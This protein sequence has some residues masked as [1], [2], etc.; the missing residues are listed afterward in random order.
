VNYGEKAALLEGLGYS[1]K[2]P[3]PAIDTATR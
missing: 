1:V 3:S 2:T